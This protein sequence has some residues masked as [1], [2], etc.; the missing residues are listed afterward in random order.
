MISGDKILASI[1]T[2]Y[3]TSNFFIQKKGSLKS[4][5]IKPTLQII[6]ATTQNY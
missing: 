6:L 2:K 4:Y 3:L 5:I 1:T